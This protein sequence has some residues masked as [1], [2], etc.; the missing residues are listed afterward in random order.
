MQDV[1]F[2]IAG[3]VAGV[4][5]ASVAGLLRRTGVTSLGTP[6][7]AGSSAVDQLLST[8]AFSPGSSATRSKVVRR[9]EARIEPSGH[10]AITVDGQVYRRVEDLPD[11]ATRDEVAAILRALPSEAPSTMRDKVAAEL[12]DAGIEPSDGSGTPA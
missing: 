11:P 4:V 6:P 10:L 12:R 9:I 7:A 1:A 3:L 2:F 5:L 8:G